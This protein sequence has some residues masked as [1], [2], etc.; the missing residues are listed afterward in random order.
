MK[1]PWR[2]AWLPTPV[3]LPGEFHGQRSLADY[4][5][6]GPKEQDRTERLTLSLFMFSWDIYHNRLVTDMRIQL[7][8]IK[9]DIKDFCK[10]HKTKPPFFLNIILLQ[11]T[12]LFFIK[13]CCLWASTKRLLYDTAIYKPLLS[14]MRT[15]SWCYKEGTIK[16][17]HFTL[18]LKMGNFLIHTK[19]F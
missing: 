6:W 7:C 11:K 14:L 2:R 5:Q 10:K 15:I 13:Q 3:F 16:S 12:Q 8:S 19:N 9:P 4:S 18:F 17:W 1:T